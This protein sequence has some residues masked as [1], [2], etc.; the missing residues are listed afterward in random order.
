MN[1]T[2]DEYDIFVI[3]EKRI[4]EELTKIEY[5]AHTYFKKW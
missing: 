3:D 4:K 2:S 5:F 1:F